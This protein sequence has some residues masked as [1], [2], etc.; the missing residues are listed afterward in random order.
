[1][2]AWDIL[3]SP[4]ILF[5]VAIAIGYLMYIWSRG[6]APAFR[7]TPNKVMPYVG[8][9]EAEGLSFQPGYQFF[10]VA[11][12]FVVVHVAA[13]VIATAP[14]DVTLWAMLTYLAVLAIAVAV[15]RWEQ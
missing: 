6:I 7:P 15:L 4:F 2:T 10:Y 3:S 13:L 12:F 1:M 8:G 9:E 14:R 5:A 11:L